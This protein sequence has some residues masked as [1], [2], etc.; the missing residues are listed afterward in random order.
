MAELAWWLIMYQDGI[1]ANGH[2]F[3]Y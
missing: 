2:S 3:Q 1:P